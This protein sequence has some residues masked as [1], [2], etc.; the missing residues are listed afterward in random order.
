MSEDVNL[1]LSGNVTQT[2]FPFTINV[3][4]SGNA[5]AERDALLVASY[6][7][8][9]GRIGDALIVMLKHVRLESLSPDEERAIID[10]KCMLYDLAKVKE[11]HKAQHILWPPLT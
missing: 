4:R 9:L 6:G 10:L 5:N 7:R 8:Q 2:I 3:G 11:E 1:P